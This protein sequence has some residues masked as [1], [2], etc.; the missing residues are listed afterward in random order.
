M[1][2]SMHTSPD[3]AIRAQ[4]LALLDRYNDA[5]TGRTEPA[6]H[7]TILLRDATGAIEGGLVGISYYDWLIVEMLF[8]PPG[9]RG[10]GVGTRLMHAAEAVALQRGCR[11]VWL[12]TASPAAEAFYHRL[13]YHIF[14]TLADQPR[15]HVRWWMARPLKQGVRQEGALAG[16]EVHEARHAEGAAMIGAALGA[17]ANARMGADP[18]RATLAIVAADDQGRLQGGLWMMVRRGWLFLDLFVIAPATRRSGTGKRILAMAEDQA[19]ALGC[20]GVWLDSFDFQAPP[21]YELHGYRRFGALA[22]YPAPHGRV[23]LN[24]RFQDGGEA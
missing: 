6:R 7:L 12:D 22:D 21:F 15:G 18:L 9:L 1:R 4:L 2:L 20:T 17:E 19:R 23:W 11:G 16:L 14:A 5:A 24:K 3:P 13:G 8:V 10:H